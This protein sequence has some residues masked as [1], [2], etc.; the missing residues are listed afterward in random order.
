MKPKEYYGQHQLSIVV[1]YIGTWIETEI[2]DINEHVNLVVPYIG[3]WI[4]TPQRYYRP[5]NAFEV[6]PYIGTWIETSLYLSRSNTLK[7]YLI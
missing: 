2:N 4:E 7:S 3:T 6:V 5:E 1:P